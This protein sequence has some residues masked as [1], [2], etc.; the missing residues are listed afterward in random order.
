[1]SITLTENAARR[2]QYFIDK[3]GGAALRLAVEQTGCSGWAYVVS[4]AVE[5]EA[6]DHLFEDRGVKVVI[7]SE[8]LPYLEGSH[9]DFAADGL[10]RTFTFD[11]PNATEECGCGES[12]TIQ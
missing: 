11:N 2:V 1:M 5:I 6:D 10:N 4:L 7:D 12:F 9:I 8:S 3:E